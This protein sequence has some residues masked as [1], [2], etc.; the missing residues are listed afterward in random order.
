[1]KTKTSSAALAAGL[2]AIFCAVASIY[3][4]SIGLYNGGV[5][6]EFVLF[7]I[8]AVIF[9]FVWYTRRSH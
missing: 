3:Q 1:M 4:L 5:P 6:P 2:A 7:A 9:G 8:L